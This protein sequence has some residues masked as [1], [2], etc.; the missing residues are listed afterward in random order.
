MHS[1][2]APPF[3]REV[4]SGGGLA[5]A[6]PRDEPGARALGREIREICEIEAE[7][8]HETHAPEGTARVAQG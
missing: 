7:V 8:N 6:A 2:R 1:A 5:P 4:R 3:P